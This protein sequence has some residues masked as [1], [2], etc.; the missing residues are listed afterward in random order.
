M[1]MGI[2]ELDTLN[3]RRATDGL[4]VVNLVLHELIAG[5]INVFFFS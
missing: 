4:G 2:S 5:D 3:R 1:F